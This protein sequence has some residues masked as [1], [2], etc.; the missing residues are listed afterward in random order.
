L[1]LGRIF[2]LKRRKDIMAGRGYEQV[3]GEFHG[4]GF[5]RAVSIII[6]LIV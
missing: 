1:V 2:F 4:A 6:N 3:S 5:R